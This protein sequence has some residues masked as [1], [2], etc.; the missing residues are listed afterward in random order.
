[1]R[2]AMKPCVAPLVI[3]LMLVPRTSTAADTKATVAEVLRTAGAAGGLCVQ[4]GCGDGALTAELAAHG[5]FI[6]HALDPDATAVEA[7]QRLLHS[8]GLYGIGWAERYA[9][10]RLPYTENL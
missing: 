5:R 4:L 6:V 9:S 7:A 8:R 10:A 3:V 1:V 2:N